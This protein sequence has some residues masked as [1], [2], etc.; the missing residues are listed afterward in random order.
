MK[1]Q[2]LVTAMFV[3]CLFF[4]MCEASE[5]PCCESHLMLG[6]L[7]SHSQTSPRNSSESHFIVAVTPERVL[8]GWTQP[9]PRTTDT[10]K[11]DGIIAGRPCKQIF[12]YLD[13]KLTHPLGI[14]CDATYGPNILDCDDRSL[15][16]L[17]RQRIIE[18]S[19]TPDLIGSLISGP[20]I[21]CPFLFFGCDPSL[22]FDR[23]Q[24]CS[25]FT[26]KE[27]G[28]SNQY[29]RATLTRTTTDGHPLLTFLQSADSTTSAN[30][31]VPLAEATTTSFPTGLDSI[32]ISCELRCAI[33]DLRATPWTSQIT[34]QLVGRNDEKI[35]SHRNVTVN[36]LDTNLVTVNAAIDK[37][38][39]MIPEGETVIS[40]DKKSYEWQQGRIVLAT[41]PFEIAKESGVDFKISRSYPHSVLALIICNIAVVVGVLCYLL[42]RKAK[43]P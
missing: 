32:T 27:G 24:A 43:K 35:L 13:S 23:Q 30:T 7:R 9:G 42:L 3:I 1:R 22:G 12:R 5:F 41:N 40:D 29:C 8:V 19:A 4:S 28:F 10:Q 34:Y 26:A 20:F 2:R 39:R 17:V 11:A 31:Q 16:S 14:E 38:L 25:L 18:Q 37:I 33:E 15:Q 6:T 21:D 36:V